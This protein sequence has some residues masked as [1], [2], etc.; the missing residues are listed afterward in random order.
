M[1]R[2]RGRAREQLR[3]GLLPVGAR[4]ARP[5]HA[6]RGARRVERIGDLA[7][8]LREPV[9]G[10]G[11]EGE[12]DGRGRQ[13]LVVEG[14]AGRDHVHVVDRAVEVRGRAIG[15]T[16]LC[17]VEDRGP[18]V[19]RLVLICERVRAARRGMT[20]AADMGQTFHGGSNV[21]ARTGHNNWGPRLSRSHLRHQR[22]QQRERRAT[23]GRAEVGDGER[24][25]DSALRFSRR[26]CVVDCHSG[27]GLAASD[28]VKAA[29]GES[30]VGTELARQAAQEFA[31]GE[32]ALP[33]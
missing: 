20:S 18:V 27:E 3:S 30:G 12:V 33:Q 32:A 17:E 31:R 16:A 5:A 9:H 4:A 10:G 29:L 19:L 22:A 25:A 8:Q 15:Q 23:I 26:E 13:A 28:H 14:R 21:H 1:P 7:G 2:A 24:G 11:A 6:V